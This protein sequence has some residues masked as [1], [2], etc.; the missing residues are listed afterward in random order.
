MILFRG[1]TLLSSTGAKRWD[2]LTNG[3]SVVAVG[4]DLDHSNGAAVVDI[5]GALLLPGGIDP[6]VHFH[7]EA[8]GTHTRDT[9]ESG[10]RA[11]ILGGTTTVID[12]IT[13]GRGQSLSGALAERRGE[14]R[15][16]WCDYGLHQSITSWDERMPEAMEKMAREGIPSFKVYLAYRNSPG[17]DGETLLAV[18]ETAARLDLLILCHCEDAAAIEYLRDK[19]YTEGHRGPEWH[20]SSRPPAT[21]SS[22]V[23]RACSYAQITGARL[24][25]V[26][27]STA[28]S[29]SAIAAAR[30]AG[31]RLTGEACLHHLVHTD[32]H[33]EVGGPEA[34]KFVMSPP[35]RSPADRRA[36]WLA[37]QEGVLDEVA[38]DHCAFDLEGQKDR[39]LDDFRAIPNGVPGVA[40]RM[41]VLYSLGVVEQRLNVW[42]WVALTSENS[43]RIFG[44]FP[45]KGL[46]RPGSDADL[47][48]WDPDASTTIA[49]RSGAHLCDYSPYEGLI[50]RGAP[51][52]VYLRGS[53]VVDGSS[54]VAP[55][56]RGRFIRRSLEPSIPPQHRSRRPNSDHP[57]RRP[58]W[59]DEGP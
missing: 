5:G 29:C 25:I 17:I 48:V 26:H 54:L 59:R 36:L 1:G 31:A 16:V 8:A 33:Y 6:H 4:P 56:P 43:A 14:A 37:L 32:S 22:A 11:A 7:H 23:A 30:Q 45:R 39:H 15:D 44:L 50:L 2:V 57:S 46:I 10:S 3:E 52:R 38:T 40:D 13:P 28:S 58:T 18:M 35:L 19:L 9:F 21:E 42:D 12:F 53:L 41:P 20:P 47:L 51:S 34:A 24:H 27:V 49:V 55:E